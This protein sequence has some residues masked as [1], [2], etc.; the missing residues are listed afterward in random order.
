MAAPRAV[1]T[2]AHVKK[3]LGECPGFSGN[4]QDRLVP[5]KKG[6]GQDIEA[7]WDLPTNK[8]GPRRAKKEPSRLTRFPIFP[9]H[10]LVRVNQAG[11]PRRSWAAWLGNEQWLTPWEVE[12]KNSH[13][14]DFVPGFG[15][16]SKYRVSLTDVQGRHQQGL[17]MRSLIKGPT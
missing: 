14:P 7:N 3:G 11:F 16:F 6:F 12:R 9:N 2:A 13:P 15:G 17:L 4:A 8:G 5:N 10:F 1:R